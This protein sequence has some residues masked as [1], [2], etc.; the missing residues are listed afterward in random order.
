[1][2]TRK[3]KDIEV[4]AVG[5]GCMAFSHGYGKIPSEEYSIDAIWNAY[6]HGCNFF[7]T[8]EVYSPNLSGIGHNELIVGKALEDVRENVVIATKLILVLVHKVS[9]S[10]YRLMLLIWVCFQP[11]KVGVRKEYP[12]LNLTAFGVVIGSLVYQLTVHVEFVHLISSCHNYSIDSRRDLLS[13]YL[14]QEAQK[15]FT[16]ALAALGGAVSRPVTDVV[17]N[18]SQM[19]VYL[20]GTE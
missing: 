15:S 16:T 11:F 17:K 4:S 13:M 9:G 7:D 3:L 2:Q 19:T 8:A 20:F 12:F 10:S 6:Q 14:P 1:M 5:M 18:G